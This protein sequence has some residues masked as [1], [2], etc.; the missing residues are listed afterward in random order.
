MFSNLY[1]PVVSGSATHS[2]SLVGE[3]KQRGHRPFV[4]TARVNA[5][6]PPYEEIDS[7]PV[8]R[9]P[10]LRMPK[11]PIA[12][13]FPWI[14]Y[15]FTPGN[16]RRIEAILRRRRPDVLHQHNH[17]FDTA[18]SSTWARR[19]LKIPLALSIHTMIRHANPLYNILLYPGDRIA[20][21]CLVAQRS[22]LLILPDCNMQQY[23][24]QAF[25]TSPTVL[26]PYGINLLPDA[27]PAEVRRLREKHNLNGKRVILSLGHVHEVRNRRDLISALPEVRKA[28]PDV[29][30]LIVGKEASETPRTLAKQLGV[31]DAVIF[32][33]PAPY[34][35]IPAY[36][37][38]ADLEAHLFYQDAVE[39]T[40]LGIASQEAMGTGKAVISAV[41]PDSLGPGML[42]H[43]ENVYLVERGNPRSMAGAIIEI[44][45]D[46]D[47]RDR[48]GRAGQKLIRDNFTWDVVCRKTIDAYQQAVDRS[49]CNGRWA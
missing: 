47:R 8:Y 28:F 23:V 16:L 33:G 6:S 44:L 10:C 29:V 18:L 41:N 21:R 9:L 35:E 26:V 39:R 25:P 36:L 14:S 17:M 24:A 15:T 22:D 46:P 7:I 2:S 1:P 11:L 45:S 42:K 43:G 40:S 34:D 3:L 37:A 19:Q 27:D 49:R 12:L 5:D 31:S 32:N 38:M 30:V 48:V 13:N 20:L 4:I